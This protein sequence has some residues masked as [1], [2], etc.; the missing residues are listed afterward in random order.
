MP[1]ELTELALVDPGEGHLDVGWCLQEE[2]FGGWPLL[3]G[4][5]F[6]S[7]ETSGRLPKLFNQD[8]AT[9]ELSSNF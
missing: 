7:A 4:L 8:V 3:S 2:V 1:Q 9:Y 6:A 5:D